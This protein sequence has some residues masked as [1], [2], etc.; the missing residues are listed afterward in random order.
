MVTWLEQHLLSKLGLSSP[1]SK[2]S[3]LPLFV[4]EPSIG[5]GNM[6]CIEMVDPDPRVYE[7]VRRAIACPFI[8][9]IR[10]ELRNNAGAYLQSGNAEDWILVEFW[11]PDFQPFIDY[12]NAEIEKMND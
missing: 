6:N 7:L 1:I 10:Y 9:D 11:N 4:V 12:L 2:K 5:H 3:S 8:D